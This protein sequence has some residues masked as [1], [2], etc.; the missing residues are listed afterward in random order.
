M[1][2]FKVFEKDD[3][4]YLELKGVEVDVTM[5]NSL[6]GR[7]PRSVLL[8]LPTP[9]ARQLGWFRRTGEGIGGDPRSRACSNSGKNRG[10][11]SRG[12]HAIAV[13]DT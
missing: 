2:Y 4:V 9:T 5:I 11:R 13:D 10:M 12:V 1:L 8:R 3:A 7:P 6:L